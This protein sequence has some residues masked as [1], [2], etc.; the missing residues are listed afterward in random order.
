MRRSRLSHLLCVL[1]AC[2]IAW[3][4]CA[5]WSETAAR[6]GVRQLRSTLPGEL[7]ARHLTVLGLRVGDDGLAAV[8]GRIGQSVAF[9]P[10]SAPELLTTCFVDARPQP[11]RHV[12]GAPLRS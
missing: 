6:G 8:Q 4:P 12:P 11:R 10:E 3:Q 1:G 7:N 2:A 5:A 9:S